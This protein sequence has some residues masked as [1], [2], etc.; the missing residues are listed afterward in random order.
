MD[1]G[2]VDTLHAEMMAAYE[3][4]RLSMLA[5]QETGSSQDLERH[6]EDLRAAMA[7]SVA[8]HDEAE[9]VWFAQLSEGEVSGCHGQP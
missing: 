5:C 7:L 8:Y 4:A 9:R 2:L 6:Q 3:T 1:M